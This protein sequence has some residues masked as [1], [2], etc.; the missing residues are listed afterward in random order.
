M[1]FCFHRTYKKCPHLEDLEDIQIPCF[2]PETL[3]LYPRS[4]P[5]NQEGHCPWTK[6][7]T[8]ATTLG[9][10]TRTSKIQYDEDVDLLG[11]LVIIF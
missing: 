5:T 8:T 1:Y 10:G 4:F 6:T 3:A 9:T 2:R 11:S 7:R